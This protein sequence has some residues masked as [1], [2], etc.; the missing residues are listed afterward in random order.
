M[1][2]WVLGQL[3]LGLEGEVLGLVKMEVTCKSTLAWPWP[4]DYWSR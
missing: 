3:C 2:L 4:L 1:P